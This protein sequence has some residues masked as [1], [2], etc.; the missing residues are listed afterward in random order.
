MCEM[1]VTRRNIPEPPE[2]CEPSHDR[3]GELP[4]RGDGGIEEKPCENHE[5]QQEY[6][7]EEKPCENHKTQ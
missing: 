4:Q 2:I 6:C 1:G 7:G 5:T 3:A